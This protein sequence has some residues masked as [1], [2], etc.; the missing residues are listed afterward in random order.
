MKLYVI[1]YQIILLGISFK[2]MIF[3]MDLILGLTNFG[4]LDT[5]LR[6]F[7][8]IGSLVYEL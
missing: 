4:I 6:Y 8:N 7:W 3:L 5:W 2:V 1:Y